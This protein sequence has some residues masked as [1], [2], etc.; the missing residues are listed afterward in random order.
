M[1]MRKDLISLIIASL[2][3]SLSAEGKRVTIVN[4]MP[5]GRINEIV[6]IDTLQIPGIGKAPFQIVDSEGNAVAHQITYD[7]KLIFPVTVEAG[8]CVSYDIV[9]GRPVV[10]ADTLACGA[11]YPRRKDDLAWEN[12]RAAYRAYGPALEKSGERAFG[13][14]IWTKSVEYPVVARRYHDALENGKGYHEDNGDG[15]D[16]YTVGPTLGGGTAALIDS[17]DRILFP[18]C[19]KSYEILDNGPLRF[20]AR[21]TYSSK[22]GENVEEIRLISLDAGEY[23]NRTEI[24]F[25]ALPEGYS[26]A[27]GIVVH[28]PNPDG[29]ALISEDGVMAYADPTDNPDAGNGIIFVGVVAPEAENLSYRPLGSAEGAA[30]GH[31]LARSPYK[32]TTPYLYYWGSGWSK[33]SMPDMDSWIQYLRE[34]RQ[35]KDNPLKSYIID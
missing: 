10:A 22:A 31:L 21:L 13:Y 23:L 8:S 25:Q 3:L 14:D 12:N 27:P 35:R 1:I 26:I 28:S 6:E 30:I 20:T 4:E 15:M 34:F 32:N 11:F 9:E 24:L 5:I 29:Y 7:G 33:G 2:A 16:A 19:F 18:Y 17:F